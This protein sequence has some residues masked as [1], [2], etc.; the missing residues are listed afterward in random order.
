MYCNEKDIYK[1]IWQEN[2]IEADFSSVNVKSKNKRE[3]VCEETRT[4][5]W[6]IN[7]NYTERKE[8]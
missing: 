6:T 5:R 1:K 8:V 7:E 3:R 4:M 2:K